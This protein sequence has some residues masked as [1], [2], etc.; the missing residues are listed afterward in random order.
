[1]S[2]WRRAIWWVVARRWRR[3]PSRRC[4]HCLGCK[5]SD[6]LALDR[7]VARNPVS[8]PGLQRDLVGKSLALAISDSLVG[9]E[10]YQFRK[11]AITMI[12]S[13]FCQEVQHSASKVLLGWRHVSGKLAQKAI[14]ALTIGPL[15]SCLVI[16]FLRWR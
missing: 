15:Q 8:D 2:T 3:L 16:T 5:Q 10:V 4:L 14:R 6:I 1:M 13:P 7:N 11:A 12:S 9:P